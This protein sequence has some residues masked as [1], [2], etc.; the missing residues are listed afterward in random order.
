MFEGAGRPPV[1][2]LSELLVHP[3]CNYHAE[4]AKT[5]DEQCADNLA[6]GNSIGKVVSISAPVIHSISPLT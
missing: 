2:A 5:Y 1:Y 4:C 3:A 6:A